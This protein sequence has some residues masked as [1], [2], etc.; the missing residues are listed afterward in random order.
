[1]TLETGC[2][3][4]PQLGGKFLMKKPKK[5]IPELHTATPA[6]HQYFRRDVEPTRMLRIQSAA[7]LRRRRT[8]GTTSLARRLEPLFGQ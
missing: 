7:R 1:M 2:G 6:E 4:V 3:I 8:D 5:A